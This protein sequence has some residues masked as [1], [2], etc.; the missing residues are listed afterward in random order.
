MIKH[1][2]NETYLLTSVK[3][4]VF[5]GYL[6]LTS[7]GKRQNISHCLDNVQLVTPNLKTDILLA[8]LAVTEWCI[9]SLRN[10]ILKDLPNR[11]GKQKMTNVKINL[12]LGTY[13]LLRD[14][15][16]ARILLSILGMLASNYYI[17]IELSP[18]VNSGVISSVLSLLRQTGCDQ[19]IVRKVSEL[20]VLYADMVENCKPKTSSLSGPELAGLMKLGTRVV[21]GIDWKWG[22]QDGPPPGEGCVIGELGDD[23]WVRVEWANGTTNSYR[24][25]KEGKYDLTLASP[26]SPVTSETDTEEPSE[27]GK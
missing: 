20:Y 26:P 10:H 21:R 25:G 4:S 8:Q 18:L 23:G 22:D 12:N 14:V 27:G 5:N 1:L 24:M 13:T 16:R 2:L 7:V 9:E 17:A 6:G 19:S 3:Y 11:N 15:P